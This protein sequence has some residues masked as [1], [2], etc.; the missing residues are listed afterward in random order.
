LTFYLFFIFIHYTFVRQKIKKKDIKEMNFL[1]L[2]IEPL[3]QGPALFNFEYEQEI[4]NLKWD[5]S[6]A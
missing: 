3:L 4:E 6:M 1:H 5:V 2:Y